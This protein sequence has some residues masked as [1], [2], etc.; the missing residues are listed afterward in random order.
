V[1]TGDGIRQEAAEPQEFRTPALWGLRL[2]RPLLHDGTAATIED[3]IAA[4]GNEAASAR[5]RFRAASADQ[6][7]ALL[8]FLK[9][10]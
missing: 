2:R 7:A 6:R 3:A 8:G 9:S 1:G 5:S 4:H 10:L